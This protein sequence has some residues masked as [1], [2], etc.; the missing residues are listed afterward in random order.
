MLLITVNDH[1]KCGLECKTV[2][3]SQSACVQIPVPFLFS[4]RILG[5]LLNLSEPVSPSEK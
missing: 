1:L 2:P 4:C 3:W 5:M